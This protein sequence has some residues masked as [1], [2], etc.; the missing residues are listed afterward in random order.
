MNPIAPIIGGVSLWLLIIFNLTVG[1]RWLKFSGA[2]TWHKWVGISL[3]VLG[4]IH[5]FIAAYTFGLIRF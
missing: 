3:V 4:P 2:F 5:G 1:M